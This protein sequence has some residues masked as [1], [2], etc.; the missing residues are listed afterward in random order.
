MWA[1]AVY[2]QQSAK[3]EHIR[4]SCISPAHYSCI[5]TAKKNKKAKT[6]LVDTAVSTWAV[7]Q[8]R[9]LYINGNQTL[10]RKNFWL[11]PCRSGRT[12]NRKQ[13]SKRVSGAAVYHQRRI[14]VYQQRSKLKRKLFWMTQS[15]RPGQY[16]YRESCK[17][18][19]IK[20]NRKQLWSTQPCRPERCINH[21]QQ[22][23]SISGAAVYHQR[24]IAVYHQRGTAVYQQRKQ[25]RS[26]RKHFWTTQPC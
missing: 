12:I 22:S 11:Q 16:I 8:P 19:A 14:A 15:C 1:R 5:S 4:R 21:D 9:E 3:Q 7:Y 10:R 13:Q 23:K 2:Q 25:N 26:M 24:C 20:M 18:R 6:F 17:S